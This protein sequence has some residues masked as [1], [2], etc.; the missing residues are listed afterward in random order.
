MA[1]SDEELEPFQM[2]EGDFRRR[3]KRT[4]EDMIYGMWA[5]HDSDEESSRYTF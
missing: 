1:Y 4:K 2:T 3:R 5:E